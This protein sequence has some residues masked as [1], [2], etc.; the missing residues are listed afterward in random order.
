MRF[1]KA[2]NRINASVSVTYLRIILTCKDI[3]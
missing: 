3:S 2:L 1:M